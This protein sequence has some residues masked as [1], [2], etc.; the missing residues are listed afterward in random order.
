MFFAAHNP[1]LGLL[2]IAPH[3][4]SLSLPSSCLFGS[5]DLQLGASFAGGLGRIR[6][7]SDFRDLVVEHLIP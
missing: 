3:C 6:D 5:T 1:A 7:C 2:N 4:L